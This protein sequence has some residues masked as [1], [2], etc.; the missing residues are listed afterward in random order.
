M[1]EF[2]TAQQIVR[3]VMRVAVQNHVKVIKEINIEL[4]RFTF[5]NPDQ[6]KFVFKIAAEG[7]ELLKDVKINID[8]V[9]GEITCNDCGYKGP[10]KNIEELEGN[11]ELHKFAL[12]FV[13]DCPKCNGKNTKITSGRQ[14]L[15][16][17]IKVD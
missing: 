14:L 11:P 2:S 8:V 6:L 17:N 3:T 10:L 5:V 7:I 16:K 9:E 1:H 13:L 15:V 4:G 12:Q